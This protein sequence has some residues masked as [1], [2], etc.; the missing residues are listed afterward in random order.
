[1]PLRAFTPME[2]TLTER[3]RLE[4]PLLAMIWVSGT[5]ASLALGNWFDLAATTVAVGVNLIAAM[6]SREIYVRRLMVNAS[7]VAATIAMIMELAGQPGRLLASLEHY[8]ILIMLC[9]LFERKGNR[10][11]VQ[12]LA[13]SILL[14]VAAALSAH[15]IWFA[16]A[17]VVH[18]ALCSYVAM[19]FT[20]KR[21]LDAAA[22]AVLSGERR[23]LE[24]QQVAWNVI[25]DWPSRVLLRRV[26][27]MLAAMLAMGAGVFLLAPRDGALADMGLHSDDSYATSGFASSVHLGDARQVYLSDKVVMQVRL[28]AGRSGGKVPAGPF[29]LRGAV[30][31]TYG[32]AVSSAW[33]RATSTFTEVPWPRS[34][35]MGDVIDDCF[36]QE[37]TMSNTLLP[38]VFGQWP[39]VRQTADNWACVADRNLNLQC[40]QSAA[41]RGPVRYEVI[42][43]AP[44]AVGKHAKYVA[45]LRSRMGEH[46]PEVGQGIY[47]SPLVAE[48]ARKWTSDLL[49]RREELEQSEPEGGD[50]DEINVQIA[51]RLAQ[52]LRENYS[53]SLDLTAADPLRDGV[54]DF[55]FYMRRGHCE[56]FA[57]ALTV[58]CQSLGVQ[59]RLA[60]G[61]MSDGAATGEPF[62]VRERDAHAWT[63]IFTPST[64][65]KVVDATP[66]GQMA[67]AH[68]QGWWANLRGMFSRMQFAWNDK[69]VGYDASARRHVAE[70]LKSFFGAIW[71]AITRAATAIWDS[72]VNLLVHGQV[73]RA[74]VG[75]VIVIGV[76]ALGAEGMLLGRIFRRLRKGP[77]ASGQ[78]ARQLD[79]VL[80]LFVLMERQGLVSRRGQTLLESAVEARERF[81]LDSVLLELVRMYYRVRWGGQ[82]LGREEL[83]VARQQARQVSQAIAP[84]QGAGNCL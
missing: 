80:K 36:V 37:I 69:V 7:V 61:F 68:P 82:A 10:D 14:M 62:D 13:M 15:Q 28:R 79:F 12:M 29:Y 24:L 17:L 16:V 53:Y 49:Q 39:I 34:T 57:S 77:E 71:D 60:T 72:V 3:R 51:E 43:L 20:I 73:D 32:Q 26:A 31:T 46:I 84:K 22:G 58:M 30:Y 63:E 48:Q 42:S 19:V 8:L 6:H 11:Y 81:G 56:Y 27:V 21:G 83:A 50:M 25:R 64:D 5:A 40:A 54:E 35:M 23:P 70:G 2:Q 1:M 44:D 66:G 9:K 41:L 74:L 52:K 65:W 78:A 59:A 67:Q 75:L 45:A 47:V 18:L 55:M 33:G 76:V 38:T 4:L